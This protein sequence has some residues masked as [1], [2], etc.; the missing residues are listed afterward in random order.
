MGR[1]FQ[2]YEA[3]LP[4]L[5]QLKVPPP[6]PPP[7]HLYSRIWLLVCRPMNATAVPRPSCAAER[8]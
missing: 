4:Y 1:K 3:H 2:P 8:P 6:P 7:K 5:L